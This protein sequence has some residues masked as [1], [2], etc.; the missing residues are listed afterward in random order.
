MSAIHRREPSFR[1]FLVNS[2]LQGKSYLRAHWAS[3]MLFG[4]VLSSP[5]IAK[6]QRRL[7]YSM[8]TQIRDRESLMRVLEKGKEV[9]LRMRVVGIDAATGEME[10][11]HAPVFSG[12]KGIEG[13]GKV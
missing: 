5:K 8:F 9:Q 7:R 13:A 6:W 1:V 2:Y 3:L 11:V 12:E 4:L 10:L